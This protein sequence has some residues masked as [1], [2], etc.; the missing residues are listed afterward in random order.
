MIKLPK[1]F[2]VHHGWKYP[3]FFSLVV[4]MDDFHTM[5]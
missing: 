4:T 1:T 3:S 2:V 5:A